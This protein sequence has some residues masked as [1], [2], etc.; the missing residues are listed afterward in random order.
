MEPARLASG[1]TAPL[2]CCQRAASLCGGRGSE[3]K[4]RGAAAFPAGLLYSGTHAAIEL[5]DRGARR[6]ARGRGA[7][8]RRAGDPRRAPPASSQA[9]AAAA[10]ASGDASQR[11]ARR[12]RDA[13]RGR[14]REAQPLGRGR[15][16]VARGPGARCRRA[17]RAAS[18][19][20]TRWARSASRRTAGSTSRCRPSGAGARRRSRTRR[21]GLHRA[22][23]QRERHRARRE[24]A[25]PAAARDRG[26]GPAARRGR[27]R[28]ASS[29]ARARP[30]RAPIASPSDDSRFWFAVD[31]DGDG[32]RG[33]LADSPGVDVLAG[34]PAQLRVTLPSVARP[35]ERV[36]RDA[37]AARCGG[38]RRHSDA[39]RRSSSRSR[40]AALEL[41]ARVALDGGRPRAQDALRARARAGGRAPARRGPERPE[42]RE[43]SAP[44]LA[45]RT[46]RAVGR[47][48]R[49]LELLGWDRH[50]GGLLRVCARRRR[51]RRRRAHRPRPLGHA[52]AR[53]PPGDVG[54]DPAPDEA[55]PRARPLRDAARL[56]VDQLDPGPP[57]RAALR[58]RGQGALLARSRLRDAVAAL[59]GAARPAGAHLRAPLGGRPDRHEL[60]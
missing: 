22:R 2:G 40:R 21:A 41:P 14:G 32:I 34:A 8:V 13:A 42:R 50:A 44:D 23:G 46:A 55:L 60:G 17:A 11:P 27:A 52:R 29:T 16:R 24:D 38:Q 28:R 1:H 57:P 59:G 26:R 51:A 49:P 54:R 7:R 35:G 39:R 58:R 12:R 30:A 47:S 25:R 37:G 31:G 19:S 6:P 48:A 9:P 45:R 53:L 5:R 4:A 43:Q 20:C 3:L 36:A 33:M 18:S 10:A 56:R 15:P